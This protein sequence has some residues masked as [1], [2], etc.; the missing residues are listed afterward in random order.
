MRR[1]TTLLGALAAAGTMALL[2]STQA[3][4]A[5]G[6]LNLG[7]RTFVDPSG[8]FNFEFSSYVG[9]GTDTAVLVFRGRDC[10]GPATGVV[11]PGQARIIDG[12]SVY[13]P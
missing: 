9:N 12:D 11:A 6:T 7:S 5:T 2:P 13:V 8:C 10:T 3:F 1:V 4:A